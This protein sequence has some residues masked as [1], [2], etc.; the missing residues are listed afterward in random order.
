MRDLSDLTD[1]TSSYEL[2]THIYWRVV[3]R[4]IGEFSELVEYLGKVEDGRRKDYVL[5]AIFPLI[6]EIHW[7][8]FRELNAVSHP[9]LW[10]Q[11][12][13]PHAKYSFAGELKRSI[14][15]TDIYCAFIDIHGY[16]ALS[17]SS[18]D[19]PLLRL[20]DVCI[21]TD[22]KIICR[23]N[24]VIGNRA[25]G[26]EIILIGTSAYDVLNTV[27]MIADYFGDKR[28]IGDSEIVRKRRNDRL[29]L[30]PLNIS[31]GMAG[32]KKYDSLVITAGGDLSGPVVNLAARMQ[33]RANRIS[34]ES[35]QILVTETVR[36]KY[37]AEASKQ[38]A[39]MFSSSQMEFLDVGPF[40]FKGVEVRI[41]EVLFME[42]D[43]YRLEYAKALDAFLYALEGGSWHELIFASLSEL[44]VSAC[45]AMP[46]F[47][48]GGGNAAVK[49]LAGRGADKF[50][51][52]D[53]SS[54][55]K[56]LTGTFE[57]L[58]QVDRVDHFLLLYIE[59][60]IGEYHR[61]FTSYDTFIGNFV[62]AN[63]ATLFNSTENAD[64]DRA[65]S[66]STKSEK[67]RA[68]L[69]A[70]VDIN[71]RMKLWRRLAKELNP[72]LESSLYLGK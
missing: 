42:S 39:T 14:T 10:G 18:K 46:A 22:V 25:R 9:V 65:I 61:I 64:Y 12:T 26:D 6:R 60:A 20:L 48:V 11:L 7:G 44:I 69:I 24:H 52:G 70:R 1:S 13:R 50:K 72:S 59:A 31:A 58:N 23:D 15:I 54:A 66:Y 30:P 40:A 4:E 67:M 47:S 43:M 32:G 38:F 63:R 33:S 62:E 41:T 56:A 35:S 34:S 19:A 27:L 8:F 45:S 29:K 71:K 55:L 17:K 5:K 51:A 57:V 49:S 3:S 68:I 16:T 53:Y 2:F 21:E 36:I 28:L 37:Q